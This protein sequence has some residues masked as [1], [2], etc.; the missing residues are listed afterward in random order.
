LRILIVDDNEPAAFLL[1]QLLGKLGQRVL[2]AN[3][4]AEGLARLDEFQPQIVFSD[5]AMP[6]MDGYQF[7]RRV[8][9][10]GL[11]QPPLLI[12][13]TGYGQESDR[14]ATSAAGFDRHLTKPVGVPMLEEL[15]RSLK[16]PA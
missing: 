9:S 11:A 13:L 6:E 1:G 8:R 16:P 2:A 5:I 3:S 7:A 4:A 14:Q 10:A 15:L 12:A